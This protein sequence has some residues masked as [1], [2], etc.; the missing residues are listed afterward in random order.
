MEFPSIS[1]KN[2]VEVEVC[3]WAVT[4]WG[5]LRFLAM[6]RVTSSEWRSIPN[7]L[8]AFTRYTLST[9]SIAGFP[10]LPEAC[11]PCRKTRGT[12][13]V[14]G[15]RGFRGGFP[16]ACTIDAMDTWDQQ[17]E[18]QPRHG[19]HLCRKLLLSKWRGTT[20]INLCGNKLN[21]VFVLRHSIRTSSSGWPL[22]SKE[23]DILLADDVI[24]TYIV[25]QLGLPGPVDSC[26]LRSL[27]VFRDPKRTLLYKQSLSPLF[28][29]HEVWY[30]IVHVFCWRMSNYW[31]KFIRAHTVSSIQLDFFHIV[32]R[33]IWSTY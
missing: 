2:S 24:I 1:R 13:Q 27:V 18:N 16:S 25:S 23:L 17:K 28:V 14:H 3:S 6:S 19:I 21:A 32:Y 8:A 12:V 4:T 31:D 11:D 33:W 26:D 7:Y 30:V 20:M 5:W 22:T 29:V 15:T 9:F 10:F